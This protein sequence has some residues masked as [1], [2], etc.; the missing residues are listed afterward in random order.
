MS[1]FRANV[2]IHYNYITPL[3]HFL[4][5][6]PLN[7]CNKGNHI[8]FYL[9]R[10]P[11]NSS[12]Y[13][14]TVLSSTHFLFVL[15]LQVIITQMLHMGKQFTTETLNS[16]LVM[17][18]IPLHSSSLEK[19]LVCLATRKSFKCQLFVKHIYYIHTTIE[20]TSNATGQRRLRRA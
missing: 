11:L 15:Q 6:S 16:V 4:M 5:E 9:I 10:T 19:Y 8:D 1:C 20:A 18:C 7:Q 14:S 12:S 2:I 17:S 3:V 13:H